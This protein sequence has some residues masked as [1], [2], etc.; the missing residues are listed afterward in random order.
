MNDASIGIELAN[1]GH[2]LGY[3][4]FPE[5][6]IAALEALCRD[7]LARHPIPPRHVLGHSD[8]APERKQDPGERFPWARLA[9]ADIGLWPEPA[10][11]WAPAQAEAERLLMAIGYGAAARGSILTAFQRHFRPERCDGLLDEETARRIAAV[12]ALCGEV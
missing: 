9:R 7:I 10:L 12:A 4:A 2:E 5:P 1:P 11:P 3:R 6:Q 8:V